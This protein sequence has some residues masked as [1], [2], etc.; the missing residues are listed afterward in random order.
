MSEW[1]LPSPGLGIARQHI[2]KDISPQPSLQT[3]NICWLNVASFPTWELGEAVC[4]C[5]VCVVCV[6]CVFVACVPC[7]VSV[8]SCVCMRVCVCVRGGGEFLCIMCVYCMLGSLRHRKHLDFREVSGSIAIAG[9]LN[10]LTW[11]FTFC[12]CTLLVM[13][14]K[15]LV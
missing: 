4:V 2:H 6:L 7:V 15:L 5:C 1:I 13:P 11:Y 14:H 3:H 12:S 10:A 8:F 9:G